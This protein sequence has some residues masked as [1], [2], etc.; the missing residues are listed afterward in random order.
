MYLKELTLNNF[1]SFKSSMVSLQ[2]D[3][4]ILVGENNSGKSNAIDALRLITPPLSGR[5]DIYCQ[6]TDIR[7]DTGT[8][9]ELSARYA[10]LN[11][12]QQ[13]RLV[14]ATSDKTM[15]DAI[16][17]LAYDETKGGFPPRPALWAGREG[18][19]PEAGS[20]EM[21][22]HVYLPA[23]RDA[24]YAL[25]SG[26]PTRIYA[27]LRHFLKDTDPADLIKALSRTTNHKILETIGGS[28]DV[29][30]EALTAGVRQQTASLGFSKDEKLI[31]I[32]RDLKFSLADH[33]IEP[34]DLSY[35]GHGYANLLY[36]ATIAVELENVSNA[37]LTL[38]LV[39]EPEAHL[40]PQLQA[41]VL[42]FLKGQ[43]VKS[44]KTPKEDGS[45]G[46]E[47]QV[48]VA[49][50]SPNL[51]A[52]VPSKNMVFLRAVTFEADAVADL[53]ARDKSD[54]A[55]IDEVT[56]IKTEATEK[57]KEADNITPI[58]RRETRSISLAEL[59]TND[60]ERRKIDRYIDVTKAS[61]MF[62]GRIFLVEG[63]AEA[64]LLPV[65][66]EKIVLKGD[67]AALRR[68]RSTT[69]VPIDGVDFQP[70]V[71]LLITPQ[72]D[73]RIADKIVIVTDG[74]GPKTLDSGLTAGKNRKRIYDGIAKGANA[75]TICETYINDYSLE[76][77]LL[78]VGN[79]DVLKDAYIVCHP[80]SEEKWDTAVSYKG[81]K[82]AESMHA[83]FKETR[84]GDFAQVLAE[85]IEDG[86]DFKVPKYLSDAIKS[87]SAE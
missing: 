15:T 76:T 42:A 7:F 84:K 80:Q 41:A 65:L 56:T 44:R 5:R 68:F 36:M 23:L 87:I 29:G 46:G 34:E 2:S 30:L 3:L 22:R 11:E 79:Q 47:I 69:F 71:K 4:T 52:S 75:A 61:F 33:G 39:E 17:G 49:T 81:D 32:A 31:D 20:H 54:I 6:L 70:Y 18:R 24:K 27:L 83:L 35:S 51:T 64:L 55:T 77:E 67:E 14:S 53:G 63:I 66:A 12:A 16:F 73:I 85:L 10:D 48:V 26:N 59:L 62:G 60:K 1:R 82:L 45:P 8:G 50:H 21:I 86:K 38:F 28:V 19:T 9:F 25:A 13:G 72:N 58:S 40:H 57:E 43:A 74:D 78:T 37:D